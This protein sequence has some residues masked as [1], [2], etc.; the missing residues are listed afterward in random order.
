MKTG[1]F[2]EGFFF[3]DSDWNCKAISL[4]PSQHFKILYFSVYYNEDWW[5]KKKLPENCILWCFAEGRYAS[6]IVYSAQWKPNQSLAGI[7]L[8]VSY[9]TEFGTLEQASTSNKSQNMVYQGRGMQHK[10]PGTWD[11]LWSHHPGKSL[12]FSLTFWRI[13]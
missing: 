3:S 2:S 7:F 8:P 9:S 4:F 5:V 1:G 12:L 6:W 11:G 13:H 10:C